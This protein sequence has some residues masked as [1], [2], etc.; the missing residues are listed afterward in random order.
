MESYYD[1][2]L[3]ETIY[4]ERLP[5]GL[6]VFVLPK[7]GFKKTYATFAT[8]YGSIDNHFQV[9]GQRA[10]HVP[11]GVAHFLEHMMFAEPNK[12]IFSTFAQQGASVN[13]FTAFDRTV[14]VISTTEQIKINL[15]TLLDFVQTPYFTDENVA[16]E[17]GVITQEINMYRDQA[18][19]RVYFGLIQALYHIHPIRI[20]ISGTVES[21][22]NITKETLHTCYDNFY[23]PTNMLLFVVGGVVPESIFTWVRNNQTNKSFPSQKEIIRFLEKEP[24]EIKVAKQVVNLPLVLS[25]CLFGCK[26]NH[27]GLTG[28]ALLEYEWATRIMLDLL[29]GSSSIIY[30]TLYEERLITDSFSGE[31]TCSSEYAFSIIGGETSS[32]DRL[33]KRIQQLIDQQ[34]ENGFTEKEFIR[35]RN[36]AVGSYIRMMN[37]P[38]TIANEFVAYRFRDMNLFDIITICET[39]TLTYVQQRLQEH[40]D[41][42]RLA[43]SVVEQS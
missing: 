40:F 28:K 41:W 23:H 42:K 3:K 12:D 15:E 38:E 11:D 36:K 25:R 43:V 32:P 14:Y 19:W 6:E 1:V 27:P 31:F 22:H 24:M 7:K 37:Y 9:T 8:K 4:Y 34:K 29:L 16:K 21:I 17:K 2:K 33:V 39:L 20:D 5:N 30:Q 35:A 18:G 10:I 26:D 13:A